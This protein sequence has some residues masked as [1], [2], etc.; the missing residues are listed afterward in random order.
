MIN[1]RPDS[2]DT[3]GQDPSVRAMRQVFA[4]VEAAEAGF[5]DA[6]GITRLDPRLNHWRR[7]ARDSF[8][9]AL[10]SLWSLPGGQSQEGAANL[11]VHCLALVMQR[12]GVAVPAQAL[13]P[14]PQ[15]E[16]L[17]KEMSS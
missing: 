16:A 2:N 5:L 8:S 1:K 7:A 6:A 15:I 11:F 4:A 3:W 12:D 9:R 13:P 10:A 17:A 14:D